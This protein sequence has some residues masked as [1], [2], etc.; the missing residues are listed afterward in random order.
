MNSGVF[1]FMLVCCIQPLAMFGLGWWAH[2][3]FV[4]YGWKGFI[5]KR[6]D[7]RDRT[8]LPAR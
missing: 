8:I 3:R 2:R 1:I 7:N 4:K 6:S 5:P